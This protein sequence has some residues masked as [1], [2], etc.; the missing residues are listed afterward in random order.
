[1]LLAIVLGSGPVSASGPFRPAVW[2]TPPNVSD[3]YNPVSIA[4]AGHVLIALYPTTT[5]HDET[6]YAA[7]RSANDGV[8]WE[9]PIQLLTARPELYFHGKRMLAASGDLV[10]ALIDSRR[11]GRDRLDLHRSVDGGRSWKAP[12]KI[13]T[14][15]PDG[16]GFPTIDGGD[17]AVSGQHVYVVWA[18]LSTS[19]VRMRISVDSGA[20]FAAPITIGTFVG[21]DPSPRV[22]AD[23][24]R[25]Y[26]LWPHGVGSGK[27]TVAG[28]RERRSLDGGGNFL[29]QRTVTSESWFSRQP[30]AVAASGAN[31]LVL[32][33]E[34]GKTL[35]LWRSSDSGASFS[36]STIESSSGLTATDLVLRGTHAKVTLE[37]SGAVYLR[38]T[39]DAGV[40]WSQRSRLPGSLYR[41]DS[42][43]TVVDG[44]TAV[45]AACRRQPVGR[46]GVCVTAN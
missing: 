27:N 24:G 11:S 28:L 33:T 45:I 8:T 35:R 12:Q 17:V 29:P 36:G 4:R 41:L 18:D 26:V 3:P 22:V 2:L 32:L 40:T 1:V 15:A 14:R 31:L 37:G 34:H 16:S 9:A 23:G 13:V 25:V 42:R 10:A 44:H 7:R 21:I 39:S 6:G 19:R 43:L 30:P 20:S 38:S 46:A 5:A